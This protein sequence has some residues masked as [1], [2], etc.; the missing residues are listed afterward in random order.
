MPARRQTQMRSSAGWNG[1]VL[2]TSSA[3]DKQPK[4]VGVKDK[5]RLRYATNRPGHV[6]LDTTCPRSYISCVHMCGA[7]GAGDAQQIH[8]QRAAHTAAFNPQFQCGKRTGQAT[9]S[10]LWRTLSGVATH[11]DNIKP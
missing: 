5:H 9:P 6:W 1:C 4:K 10:T 2:R 7:V 3:Y 8:S 11:S